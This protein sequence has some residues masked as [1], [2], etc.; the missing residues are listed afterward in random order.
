MPT[1]EERE[2]VDR[3]LGP[4][5]S[6][7]T[8]AEQ[9]AAADDH[10][11]YGGFHGSQARRHLLLPTLH[12]VQDAIGWISHGALN[13]IAKRIPVSP[14]EAYGVASF[15]ELLTTEPR[16][17]RVAHVC[18]D[19]VCKANGADGALEQL[20]ATFGPPGAPRGD[21]MWVRSPCLG[22]CERGSAAF[23]QIA[24]EDN[25]VLAPAPPEQIIEILT[26]GKT[27][28][29]TDE[30]PDTD[31]SLPLL[32]RTG[33][34]TE[35][36][37]ASYLSD[38]GYDG[39]R[40]AIDL[41]PD[42]AVAEITASKLRGRGGAAF[43]AGI[44]WEA[45]ASAEGPKYAICNADESEPGT[46]KDRLLLECDPFAVIEGLTIAGFATGAELGYIYIRGEY[47][48]AHRRL[49]EALTEARAGQY[50]GDDV[51]GSGFTFDIELRRGA[52]AYICGEETALFNS[53][54]GFRGEPRQKPPFPTE[55][56]LFGRPTLVNNVESLANV[57]VILRNGGEAFAEVGTEESTGTKLFCLSGNVAS[58]GVYEVPFG[59]TARELINVAGGVE[60]ELGAVLIGG[61]AGSFI[62]ESD[63]DLALTFEDTLA[64]GFGLGSGVVAVF[65]TEADMADIVHRIAEFFADESCGLCVPCR[66]GT[67]RQGEILL[68]IAADGDLTSDMALLADL[69]TVLRD[70]S[71]CGLG[72]AA[73]VA[74]QSAISIGLIGSDA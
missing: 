44:K 61:A 64:R 9:R 39:L 66:V 51:A 21:A 16:P 48:L 25:V 17:P 46:F 33:S 4:P 40:R 45:V 55:A 19:I 1:A 22:Q 31:R 70:G 20:T 14:A 53:I 35:P 41:G 62:T 6:L 72:Q 13:Y 26:T 2:A 65:N 36:T 74:V 73:S 10:V 8:G 5:D 38:G 60:G 59:A 29:T 68:R 7:W 43:P 24:G 15:Y 30:A 12:E 34:A 49:S 28:Q 57:S 23:V 3:A 50:I 67:V 58:P 18:D 32:Q 56:G 27:S 69:D 47:P 42:G 71:I 63:L 11:A 52:G 54:E 37:L